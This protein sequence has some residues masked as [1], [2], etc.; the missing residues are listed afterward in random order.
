VSRR[1]DGI[2]A[3]GI[4]RSHLTLTMTADQWGGTPPPH[5]YLVAVADL[6]LDVDRYR[7]QNNH[8]PV[9]STI[10]TGCSDPWDHTP[11]Q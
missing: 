7:R 5:W 4:L 9:T 11:P 3:V 6:M 10:A 1:D 8:L 2:D